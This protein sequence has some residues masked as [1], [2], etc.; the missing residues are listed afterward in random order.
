[1]SERKVYPEDSWHRGSR[2]DVRDRQLAVIGGK[3]KSLM[4]PSMQ[5]T[6][7]RAR[8]SERQQDVNKSADWE[9]SSVYDR[10][11]TN[12]YDTDE[13]GQYVDFRSKEKGKSAAT[14]DTCDKRQYIDLDSSGRNNSTTFGDRFENADPKLFE[15]ESKADERIYKKLR[16]VG[17]QNDSVFGDRIT[18]DKRGG[19]RVGNMDPR[20]AQQES[21]WDERAY[22]QIRAVGE[23]NDSFYNDRITY[24]NSNWDQHS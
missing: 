17:D 7:S 23:E 1:M 11:R 5:S 2:S 3:N 21:T 14:Y 20:Q 9:E 13:S 18:F 10:E 15:K 22:K 19:E 8:S 6:H 24:G 16:S 4:E 12:L